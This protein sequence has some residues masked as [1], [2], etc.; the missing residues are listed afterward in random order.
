M[1]AMRCGCLCLRAPTNIQWVRK[2][3]SPY[4]VNTANPLLAAPEPPW[5]DH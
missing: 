2:A 5:Q 3:Q 1:A 4:S